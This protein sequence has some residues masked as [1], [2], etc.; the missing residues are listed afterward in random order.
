MFKN[1]TTSPEFRSITFEAHNV[2]PSVMN[3]I[4]RTIITDIPVV[5][6]RGEDNPSVAVV[7]NNGPLHNEIILHRFGLIPIHLTEQET[8]SF[9]ADDY[10][11]E[12]DVQNKDTAMMN[13]TTKDI[14]V[15]K[16]GKELTAKEAL[17]LFPANSIT[18]QHVLI[19]RLRK[20]EHLHVKGKAVVDTSRTHAG[21]SPGFCTSFPMED[22]AL[23]SRATNVLDKERA[24]FRNEYGDPTVYKVTIE[25]ECGLSCKYLMIKS[26]EIIRAKLQKLTQ[27]LYMDESEKVKVDPWED[28]QNGY[29]FKIKDEDD[30]LGYLLQSHMHQHYVREKKPTEQGKQICFVGYICPHPL[31]SVMHLRVVFEEPASIKE[32]ID[33]VAEQ[34]RRII[35]TLQ[36]L[37]T[38][39]IRFHNE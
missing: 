12:L 16:N 26:F 21:F 7:Q 29:E 13:V 3:A 6:F 23:S 11:F 30:T 1:L 10:E 19:T 27:E 22:P 39:W 20:G 9:E 4:R 37:E 28:G 15:T 17:R 34:C 2:E 35:A 38:D 24:Y 31:E 14:K 25:S 36:T 8:E 18:K 5:G 33:A 32:H